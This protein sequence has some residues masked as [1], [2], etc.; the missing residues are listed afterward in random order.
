MS[1]GTN[2]VDWFKDTFYPEAEGIDGMLEEA[3]KVSPG[4]EGLVSLPYIAGE[5]APIYDADARAVFFGIDS[6]H[7]RAH[8]VRAVLEGVAFA[9]YDT[10]LVI[11][12]CG[13]EIQE[14]RLAGGG[15]R[16][17]L[18][19]QIKADVLGTNVLVPELL[20]SALLGSSVIAAASVG[21]YANLHEAAKKMVKIKHWIEPN[22]ANHQRYSE[23][24]DIYR[25]VYVN[26]QKS[27][28]KLSE[29]RTRN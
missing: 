10:C 23:L 1:T 3:S 24:F 21:M 2:L 18:W 5:R 25:D 8:F 28:S 14:A 12:E 9:V 29:L 27:F 6:H 7:T 26:L 16:S 19:N 4:A 20:E 17:S 13:G 11:K 22:Q 15:A